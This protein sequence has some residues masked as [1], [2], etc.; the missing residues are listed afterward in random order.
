MNNKVE[1]KKRFLADRAFFE[2]IICNRQLM[3]QLMRIKA[4][5]LVHSKEHNVILVDDFD[6]VV[7]SSKTLS[8]GKVSASFCKESCPDFLLSEKDYFSKL[9]RFAIHLTKKKPYTSIVILTTP[10]NESKLTK[11][12]HMVGIKSVTIKSGSEASY[13]INGYNDLFRSV[14][15]GV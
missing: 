9:I 7:G 5:S 10:S 6:F 2:D 1:Y 4:S 12:K 13:L 3:M 14:R 11:N 8:C 15:D